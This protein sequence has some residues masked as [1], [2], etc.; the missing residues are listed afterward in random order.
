MKAVSA[1]QAKHRFGQLI[2]EARAE[3][4]VVE[5]HGRPVVV[6]LAVEEYQRVTGVT[7]E[8]SGKTR[9]SGEA[10]VRKSNDDER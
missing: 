6:V 7:V 8:P 1:S 5:K 2:I 9:P 3:L 4:V 10:M